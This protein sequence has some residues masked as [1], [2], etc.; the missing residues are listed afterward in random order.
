MEL[1]GDD[2]SATNDIAHFNVKLNGFGAN[3]PDGEDA[4]KLGSLESEAIL[5][6]GSTICLLPASKVKPIHD[7]FGVV[8][9]EGVLA[10]FADCAWRGDKGRGY[11]F[12][13]KF[14]GKTIRVPLREMVVNA[15]DELQDQLMSDPL[16]RRY[17]GDWD[18]ICIFGI[19]STGDFGFKGNDF[20]LLGD[21]FL[22]SAYVVYDLANEQ[23]GLAQAN[24]RSDKSNIVEITSGANLP[25]VEGVEGSLT[26]F[27]IHYHTAYSMRLSKKDDYAGF[28]ANANI[29]FVG[30]SYEF[31]DSA[32]LLSTPFSSSRAAVAAFMAA[33]M[34]FV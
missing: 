5:D 26:K 29:R 18:S 13:F 7:R 22:R 9:I 16:A 10:P 11:S 15:F 12:D 25:D 32:A 14:A 19:G 3:V 20:T 33:A 17:F 21:T 34:L 27:P 8:S 28:A 23:L 6:S 2:L 31:D 24:L 4:I 30:Q 1:H